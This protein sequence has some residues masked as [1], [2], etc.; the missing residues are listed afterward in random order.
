MDDDRARFTE[1]Y[2]A[3]RMRVWAY[4]ASRVGGQAAD[5]VVSETFMVAWRRF[6]EMPA[7][8][9]PWLLGVARNVIRDS[10]R[11]QTRRDSLAAELRTWMRE[12]ESD[13]ADG[14]VDRMTMLR[15]LTELPDGD[16]EVLTLVSWQ[17]LSPREA[18]RVVG[19]STAALRV[20]LHRARR[21]LAAAMSTAAPQRQHRQATAIEMEW[22]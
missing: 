12:A 14:V 20:R 8:S 5:E 6:A 11:A 1:L 3:Y 10:V 18:A 16:R 4:A 22:R 9:L 2:D 17:G 19:C 15:A 21:R 7:A 13:V